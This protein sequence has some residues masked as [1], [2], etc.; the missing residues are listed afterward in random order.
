MAAQAAI[1]K[2][3]DYALV[4]L[5]RRLMRLL[6]VLGEAEFDAF[7]RQLR[8]VP[9]E[10]PVF[11]TGLARSGTTMV[12]TLLAQA[13][14]VATHRYRDFPFLCVPLAWNWLQDRL[15]GGEQA[16]ERPHRDRIR[17]TKESAEAFEE[18]IWQ[19]FFPWVHDAARC[20][21]MDGRESHAEFEAFFT[22]H[23]RKI[24]WLRGGRRYVSKGNYNLA[25]IEYLARLFPTARFVVPV[26]AP[27]AHVRSLG[28]Q[29]ALFCRYAQGDARV[30]RY[31]AAAG[32]YE[33]GPQR[34]PVNFDPAKVGEIEAAWRE[35]DDE[36]GYA[37][38]WAQAYAHVDRLRSDAAIASRILVVRFEDFCA[39]PG[40]TA[41]RILE[42]CGLTDAAG[43]VAAA[44]GTVSAPEKRKPVEPQVAQAIWSEV[45]GVAA[46]FG[47][48]SAS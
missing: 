30:P 40:A 21:V 43:R 7:A 45:A 12:L 27:L 35:G 31:L 5:S 47:Y 10:A 26:R 18:P 23:L 13:D 14:G 39:Q 9:I 11:V 32:H 42:F 38:Q 3:R 28:E 46:R 44:A 48:E 36:R 4:E 41:R 20:H 29:H 16:V 1:L 15:G 17:I 34:R 19:D 37:R 24:L 33:F 6:R 25:R 22:S 8:Q 2:G